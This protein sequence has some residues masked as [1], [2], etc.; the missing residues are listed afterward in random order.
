M[1]ESRTIAAVQAGDIEQYANLVERYQA[2]LIIHCDRLARDRAEAEDLA[3]KAFIKAYEQ[4]PS[5]DPTRARFSTWL[6]RIATNMAIDHLR[7]QKRQVSVEDIEAL[8]PDYPDD[9]KQAA[10]AIDIR[11]AV[12]GLTPSEHRQAIEAFYWQ[13]KSCQAIADDMHVSVNTV[14]SWLHRAKQQLRS[15]IV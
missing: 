1:K 10:L 5:F 12:A 15:V 7:R 3:Q 2:G 13:G 8:V 6:Y 14:K 4:L 9:T 11:A